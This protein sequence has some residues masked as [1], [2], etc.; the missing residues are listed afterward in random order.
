MNTTTNVLTL[1]NP[2]SSST[3]YKYHPSHPEMTQQ[4]VLTIIQATSI[5]PVEYDMNGP[6][7]YNNFIY[8]V[9]LSSPTTATVKIKSPE[10]DQVQP[11]TAPCPAHTASLIVRLANPDPG[12]GMNN[13][14]RVE[15]EVAAIGLARQALA[16]SK[17]SHIVPEIYAWGS[18]ASGQ[19]FSIQ[20]HMGGTMPDRGFDDL[21]LQDKTAVFGQMADILALLQRLEMPATVDG[22]GGLRFDG[23]GRLV[24]AQMS[25]YNKGP[26]ATYKDFLRAI[27]DVKL[28]EADENP[29]VEGWRENG[30]RTKL[31]DFIHHRLDTMSDDYDHVRK[32]LVHSDF[33]KLPSPNDSGPF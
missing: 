12:T 21:T 22:F 5:E 3:T 18:V 9:T 16:G 8:R 2:F 27:F 19:G 23:D 1:S 4:H 10:S 30:L 14:N 20:Q 31:D 24:S 11:G 33:S 6:F 29:V 28:Q 17:Y 25:L 7:P 13:T 32:V 26:C 15:N